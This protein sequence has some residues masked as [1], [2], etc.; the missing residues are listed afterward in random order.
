MLVFS[1]SENRCMQGSFLKRM[2]A[3]I[4]FGTDA[5]IQ[6]GHFDESRN[7]LLGNGCAQGMGQIPDARK[8]LPGREGLPCGQPL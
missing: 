6:K 8:L 7:G 1:Y 4:F 2:H 3:R 5:R